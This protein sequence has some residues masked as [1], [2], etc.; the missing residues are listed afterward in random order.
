MVK[1]FTPNVSIRTADKGGRYTYKM[2]RIC[3]NSCKAPHF[4]QPI[5]IPIC[6]FNISQYYFPTR[7]VGRLVSEKFFLH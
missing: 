1:I 3:M 7:T 2:I 6:Y 5:G 4:P